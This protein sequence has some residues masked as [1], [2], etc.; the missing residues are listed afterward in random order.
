VMLTGF[1]TNAAVVGFYAAFAASYPTHV[2][3]TGTGF[4]LSIGRGGAALSPYLAGLLFAQ[5]SGLM[6]VSLV[7]A[8]GSLLA[9][10]LLWFLPLKD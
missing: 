1:A 5:H 10:V 4:A 6:T 7:M 2:K 9:L 3:A 8:A